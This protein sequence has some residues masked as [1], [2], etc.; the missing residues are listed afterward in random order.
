MHRPTKGGKLDIA[1]MID[2][3]VESEGKW[4]D[5]D[6]STITSSPEDNDLLMIE[7]TKEDS[8]QYDDNLTQVDP[9]YSK[10]LTNLESIHDSG[11]NL[12]GKTLIMLQEDRAVIGEQHQDNGKEGTSQT[13]DELEWDDTILEEQ[14]QEA[15][16]GKVILCAYLTR[17]ETTMQVA[18]PNQR[19]I[20]NEDDITPMLRKDT[21]MNTSQTKAQ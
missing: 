21:R 3:V 10:T 9:T 14:T 7:D 2:M 17:D 5:M 15:S 11:D 16:S 19:Q 18:Q 12:D 20:S 6:V 1:D 4:M 13:S 8:F